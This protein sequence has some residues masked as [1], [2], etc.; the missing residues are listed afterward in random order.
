[1]LAVPPKAQQ[2]H[3]AP[4]IRHEPI[5]DE[6]AMAALRIA[7]RAHDA[8]AP[9]HRRQRGGAASELLGLHV[10]GVRGAHT[11]QGFAFPVIRDPGLPEGSRKRIFRELRVAA[12]SRIG[13]HVDERADAGFLE[14]GYE[15]L[16]AASAVA[17]RVDQA[18]A[19]LDFWSWA[20]FFS[21]FFEAFFSP[22]DSS[23]PEAGAVA[24]P[25]SISVTSARGALSPLRNPVLRMRR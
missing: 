5:G 16:G 3:N 7:L 1:M 9:W 15:L 18:V 22:F 20:S 8:H 23:P 12:R 2:V 24:S 17:D 21:V 11:A 4:A 6:G 14:D 19:V 13:T 10:F 25:R